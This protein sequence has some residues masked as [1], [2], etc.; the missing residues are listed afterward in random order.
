MPDAVCVHAAVVG[1]WERQE[2]FIWGLRKFGASWEQNV[3][4]LSLSH[5]QAPPTSLVTNRFQLC[6]VLTITSHTASRNLCVIKEVC[7][8]VCVCGYVGESS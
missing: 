1:G 6:T 3:L 4:A 8:Y 5:T 2:V 7:A